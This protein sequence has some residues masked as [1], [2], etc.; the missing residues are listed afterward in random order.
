M[1]RIHSMTIEAPITKVINI[2]N[3][4]QESSPMPVTEALDRVL[5][6]LRTT[7]LYSPQFGAKDDDPHANDLVGGLMSDGLR[8]LSRNEYVLSTKNLQQVPSSIIV[9]VSLHDVPSQITR[10]MEKEEHWDF[11]IFELEAAT[12]KR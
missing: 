11:N 5:E 6:I 2:I 8:R 4:A 9:P 12:H 10:A 1:A 7:E 3:A